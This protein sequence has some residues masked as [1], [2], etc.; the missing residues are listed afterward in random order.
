MQ[1]TPRDLV[2]FQDA[3]QAG[4][5]RSALLGA[6]RLADLL[7][8]LGGCALALLVLLLDAASLRRCRRRVLPRPARFQ[9]GFRSSRG[10]IRTSA[11]PRCRI[12]GPVGTILVRRACRHATAAAVVR[13]RPRARSSAPFAPSTTSVS[14]I[15]TATAISARGRVDGG[16][17][18]GQ[19]SARAQ[20]VSHADEHRRISAAIG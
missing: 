10:R 12:R 8:A 6:H 7:Q 5:R 13:F 14:V 11:H 17:R 3:A 4:R 18:Q 15:C 2:R 20:H 16:G 9:S 1:R 19:R